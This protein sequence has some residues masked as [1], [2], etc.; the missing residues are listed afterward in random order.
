M[1]GNKLTADEVEDKFNRG[2]DLTDFFTEEVD[3]LTHRPKAT[4]ISASLPA[5]MVRQIDALAAKTGKER[6]AIIQMLI[7]KALDA[8]KNRG[9]FLEKVLKEPR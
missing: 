8:K 6:G 3:P 5:E 9:S 2:E 1:S 4:E 7:A